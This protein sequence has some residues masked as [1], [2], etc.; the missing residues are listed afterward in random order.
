MAANRRT[1]DLD[2]LSTLFR[3][4]KTNYVKALSYAKLTAG[5]MDQPDA[6]RTWWVNVRAVVGNGVTDALL[7]GPYP[8]ALLDEPTPI[9]L[10][11]STELELEPHE[12]AWAALS[13][14]FCNLLLA[15]VDWAA[16]PELKTLVL[17]AG[18]HSGFVDT[19]DGRGFVRHLVSLSSYGRPD[20]QDALRLEHAQ[21]YA[22]AHLPD[23][24][25]TMRFF[26]RELEF[27]F[28]D[29]E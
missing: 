24:Q 17:G 19:R 1:D 25:K 2:T 22:Q 10:L 12:V 28:P 26:T 8:D 27:R 7:H 15:I 23:A 4:S 6:V 3:K 11:R 29:I 9:K 5:K 14:E 21:I 16:R 18:S 20:V 13:G